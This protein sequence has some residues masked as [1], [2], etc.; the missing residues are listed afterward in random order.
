MN[1]VFSSSLFAGRVNIVTG[2]GTGIGFG[3]AKGLLQSGSHVVIASRSKDKIENAAKE[4]QQYSN[5]G[6]EVIGLS[7]D[8]RNRENCGEMIEQTIKHFGRLDGLCNN[9][10][11]QF[12]A[13]AHTISENG[14]DAVVRTNLYGTWNM[15]QEAHDQF[16]GENGGHIVNIVTTNRTGMAGLSHTSAARAGVKS[17]S[18]S[19]GV[20][21][22][23]K[24]I[25]INNIG[26]GVVTSPT[27]VANYGPLGEMMFGNTEKIIPMGKLGQVDEHLVAPTMF[28]LSPACVYVT[29]QTI[30]V[31]GGLSLF[32]NHA[33]QFMEITGQLEAE[34]ES[35]SD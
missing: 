27:A 3:I 35:E 8:I 23:R 33:L 21:W 9:G 16:M 29:G 12:Q 30:D 7:C 10:G 11:G 25:T 18:Q 32:N 19:I 31:C 13:K 17:L 2:G 20:E 24:G 26:P 5:N 34:D 22:A 14:F 4:L 6:A 1:K 28:F 15:M